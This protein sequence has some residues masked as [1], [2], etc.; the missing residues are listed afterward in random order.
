MSVA[1]FGQNLQ[2]LKRHLLDLE[3]QSNVLQHR[4]YRLRR[5]TTP[6]H[7]FRKL[8]TR[9]LIQ[10]GGLV[11][12]AGLL[13]TLGITMGADLQKDAEVKD[14][15]SILLGSLAEIQAAL[16]DEAHQRLCLLKGQQAFLDRGKPQ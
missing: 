7:A 13:Q 1:P 2:K 5:M 14:A 15:V 8:R 11:E 9:T 4:V 3:K 12:K 16:E 6:H 10:L